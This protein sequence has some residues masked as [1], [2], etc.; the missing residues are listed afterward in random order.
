VAFVLL[1]GEG[2]VGGQC[3]ALGRFRDRHGQG[4]ERRCCLEGHAEQ[5]MVAENQFADLTEGQCV[6]TLAGIGLL[7]LGVRDH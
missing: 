1:V 2:L 5:K 6:G 3:Q 7:C 4:E